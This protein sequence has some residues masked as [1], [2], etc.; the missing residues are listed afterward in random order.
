ML[1]NNGTFGRTEIEYRSSRIRAGVVGR[2]RGQPRSTRV[3]RP[4][5]PGGG[6][7]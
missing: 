1:E 5:E 7:R 6:V 3:R 2:R 4:P